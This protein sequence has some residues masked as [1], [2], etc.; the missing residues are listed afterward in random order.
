MEYSVDGSVQK[1]IDAHPN[2]LETGEFYRVASHLI[3]AI[4]Y[5]HTLNIV[6]RD[7]KPDNMLVFNHNRQS[8][9]KISDFG[10]A[11]QL[12]PDETYKSLYGTEEYIH[13]HIYAKYYYKKLQ[14]IAPVDEFTEV[15]DFW[16]IGVFLYEAATGHLPFIP[17]KGRTD[18]NKMYEMIAQKNDS[19]ISAAEIK[20]KIEWQDSLPDS[21]KVQNKEQLT[22]FLAGMLKVNILLAFFV[23]SPMSFISFFFL[24]H[25]Y[26]NQYFQ[27]SEMWSFEQMSQASSFI[28]SNDAPLQIENTKRKTRRAVQKEN[29]QPNNKKRKQKTKTVKRL[30]RKYK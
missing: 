22:R 7:I 4:E 16:S 2:G 18:V 17:E 19:Q 21:C 15:Y 12:K 13:P 9:Y 6:H 20:G 23:I 28:K 30:R 10:A 1:L 5:L 3:N 27:G 26:F 8:L 29:K 24:L 25:I 14:I 11:R